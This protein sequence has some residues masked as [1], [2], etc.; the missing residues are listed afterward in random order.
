[1]VETAAW[2]CAD[3]EVVGVLEDRDGKGAESKSERGETRDVDKR[4]RLTERCLLS[5]KSNGRSGCWSGRQQA[6]AARPCHSR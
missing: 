3:V 2:A 1:M 6:Q 4:R 5:V